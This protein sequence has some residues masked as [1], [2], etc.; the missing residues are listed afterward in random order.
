MET[1][2]AMQCMQKTNLDGIVY[3]QLCSKEDRKLLDYSGIWRKRDDN[4]WSFEHNIFREYMVA[5]MLSQMTLDH[6]ISLVTYSGDQ[7]IIKNSW[8]NVLSFLIPQYEKTDIFGWLLKTNPELAVKFEHSRVDAE[9]RRRVFLGIVKEC[10]SRNIW[11]A[12]KVNNLSEL[13]RFGQQTET[14]GYLLDEIRD[15][16]PCHFRAK[17]NALKLLGEFS[18]LF[19]REDEVKDALLFCCSDTE[20]RKNEKRDALITM[21]Q[22][23]FSDIEVAD[24]LIRIFENSDEVEVRFGLYY[25]LLKSN[26]QNEY[27]DYFFG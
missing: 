10:K 20:T 9:L 22:L 27:V 8:I 5:K 14:L 24:K 25:Y 21:S 12:Q 7:D 4:L 3:Q 26:L 23:G 17:N 13:V 11:I 15:T 2:F 19:G 1:A 16:G 18:D 6:I